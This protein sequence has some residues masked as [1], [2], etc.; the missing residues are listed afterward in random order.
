MQAE[1]RVHKNLRMRLLRSE[2]GTSKR[3]PKAGLPELS[4]AGY[5]NALRECESR[6]QQAVIYSASLPR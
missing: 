4:G 1:M 3:G 5:E 6:G 2:E